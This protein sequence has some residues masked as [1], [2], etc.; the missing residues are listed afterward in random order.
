VRRSL[1][2]LLV[3][4]L[5]GVAAPSAL[6][7]GPPVRGGEDPVRYQSRL[8]RTGE[9][10]IRIDYGTDRISWMFLQAPRAVRCANSRTDAVGLW[11]T[12]LRVGRTRRV[13]KR[14]AMHTGKGDF[15]R[16]TLRFSADWERVTGSFTTRYHGN[17]RG[18]CKGTARFS[19]KRL[20]PGASWPLTHFAGTTA[21]DLPLAFDATRVAGSFVVR[22]ARLGIR[23]SCDDE[24]QRS[25]DLTQRT[26]EDWQGYIEPD[27]KF[28]LTLDPGG[29][30]LDGT[31]A[32]TG[33][34]GRLKGSLVGADGASCS[35]PED[36]TFTAQPA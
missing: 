20:H 12:P 31:L 25:F 34:S 7:A 28:S 19:V 21:Q 9:L 1:F 14:I 36:L 4:G 5:A 15:E 18:Y 3:I 17:Y 2:V 35:A 29:L 8:G 11:Q 22:K 30:E 23:L 24:Q 26:D 16:W 27:G 10:D 13:T 32:T 33:A 6:A